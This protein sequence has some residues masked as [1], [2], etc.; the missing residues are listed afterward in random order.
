MGERYG[1]VPPVG[2]VFESDD[3]RADAVRAAES[4]RLVVASIDAG[5]LEAEPSQ[6]AYLEGAADALDALTVSPRHISR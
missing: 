3:V 4:L 5:E 1:C 2:P 6:R